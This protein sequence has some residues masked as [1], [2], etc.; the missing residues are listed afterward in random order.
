MIKSKL[1]D[2]QQ[3]HRH[4]FR[5]WSSAVPDQQTVAQPPLLNDSPLRA[6]GRAPKIVASSC[7][8]L[9]AVQEFGKH[10]SAKNKKASAIYVQENELIVGILSE[11][12]VIN[13]VNECN[14]NLKEMEDIS[15][16]DRMNT[17]LYF[18]TKFNTVR[19]SLELLNLSQQVNL[20]LISDEEAKLITKNEDTKDPVQD[21]LFINGQVK[22]ITSVIR[23]I[24]V[25]GQF[26]YDNTGI[27]PNSN[28]EVNTKKYIETC[29]KDFFERL[30]IKM[31][32]AKTLM[33]LQ[34]EKLKE[35]SKQRIVLN[36]FI[37]DKI[38][39]LD[40]I[41][42]MCKYDLGS[43]AVM[44]EVRGEPLLKGIVTEQDII[45]RAINLNLDVAT[46]PLTDIMTSK[47]LKKAK[48]TTPLLRCASKMFDN[49][50]RHLPVLSNKGHIL[51]MVSSFDLVS[52][53]N[54]HLFPNIY[55]RK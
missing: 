45:R 39:I 40:A 9:E 28:E 16:A 51:G 31:T 35:G 10:G 37:S 29:E 48:M 52:Y 17:N 22:D 36:T 41:Q 13:S 6:K 7:S 24:D 44:D 18:G 54:D 1:K 11:T 53:F 19:D 43:V 5:S 32:T 3:H 46:T 38:S 4:L 49:D 55:T 26:Y 27:D 25:L 23:V 14:G 42:E 34:Q 2:I 8:L 12:Q 21:G 50:I 30:S 47:N 33:K 15:V 20:P